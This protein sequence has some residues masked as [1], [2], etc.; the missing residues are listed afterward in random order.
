M[1]MMNKRIRHRS[2]LYGKTA[3]YIIL[4][5]SK[6]MKRERVKMRAREQESESI[7]VCYLLTHKFSVFIDKKR[8]TIQAKLRR[9]VHLSHQ[10]EVSSF[11]DES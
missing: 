8:Q 2:L 10:D 11:D 9:I 7:I 6:V 5:I 4:E 3:H 1:T